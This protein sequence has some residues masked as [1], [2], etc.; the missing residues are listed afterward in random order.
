VKIA[1]R[2]AVCLRDEP[3]KS[4]KG[5]TLEGRESDGPD[6]QRPEEC[7]FQSSSRGGQEGKFKQ[8]SKLGKKSGLA[9]K[10]STLPWNRHRGGSK[11]PLRKKA[12]GEKE[13][14]LKKMINDSSFVP[15]S[16]HGRGKGDAVEKKR[17][18]ENHIQGGLKKK[19]ESV[20]SRTAR[21]PLGG[22]QGGGE[23]KRGN[24]RGMVGSEG[25]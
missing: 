3:T 22:E 5:G 25:S 1:R 12:Q 15:R 19:R 13:G 8:S 16:C 23:K 21:C 9:G 24:G 7:W 17:G 18:G 20:S 6:A 2:K 11:G 14:E 4:V 10:G